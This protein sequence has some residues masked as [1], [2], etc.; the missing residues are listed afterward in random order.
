MLWSCPAFEQVLRQFKIV[1]AS[2][3]IPK[4]GGFPCAFA[5]GFAIDIET[6]FDKH[7]SALYAVPRSQM[8]FG[9]IDAAANVQV[10][11]ASFAPVIQQFRVL[12]QCGIYCFPIESLDKA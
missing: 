7:I 9:D 12:G 11:F 10:V 4:R 5:E 3:D 2:D 1:A 6:R 8:V